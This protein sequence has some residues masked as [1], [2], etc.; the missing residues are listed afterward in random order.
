MSWINLKGALPLSTKHLF[1]QYSFL[2]DASS[3][4]R[5]WQYWW[6]AITWSTW[7][8]RNKILFSGA[9]FDGIKL[10]EDATF[11]MWTWLHNL[12]KDFTLHFNQWSNL[13]CLAVEPFLW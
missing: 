1:M 6:L 12:E 9:T 7:Q 11:L 8:L 13:C 4:N 3:R 2:Q 10:V 5:R